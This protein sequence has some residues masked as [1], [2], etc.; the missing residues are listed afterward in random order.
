MSDSNPTRLIRDGDVCEGPS[1]FRVPSRTVQ[2]RT[3]AEALGAAVLED[4]A[5]ELLRLVRQGHHVVERL[6]Q[7]MLV[8]AVTRQ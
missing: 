5:I 1:R 2:R 8:V 4:L 7:L 6:A 3:Q